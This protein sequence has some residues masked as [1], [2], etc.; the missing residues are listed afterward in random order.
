MVVISA[1]FRLNRLSGKC[2]YSTYPQGH[3]GPACKNCRRKPEQV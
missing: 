3:T 1:Y 2:Q